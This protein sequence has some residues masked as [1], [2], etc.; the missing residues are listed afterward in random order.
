VPVKGRI[1]WDWHSPLWYKILCRFAKVSLNS[2]RK[3]KD[4]FGTTL[5]Q[6]SKFI[7]TNSLKFLEL[8]YKCLEYFLLFRNL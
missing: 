6:I 2:N 1:C 8:Q 3:L 5:E 7:V 4:V